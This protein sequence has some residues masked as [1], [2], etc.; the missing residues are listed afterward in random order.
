MKAVPKLSKTLPFYQLLLLY[1]KGS[2]C[3]QYEQA[4]SWITIVT[5]CSSAILRAAHVPDQHLEGDILEQRIEA[6]GGAALN[7][8]ARKRGTSSRFEGSVI[9]RSL[10][11]HGA[12][13]SLKLTPY[14][15]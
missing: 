14:C 10:R 5:E 4:P 6:T 7:D 12:I 1:R 9:I 8:E 3:I 15:Y 13:H 2:D 11:E